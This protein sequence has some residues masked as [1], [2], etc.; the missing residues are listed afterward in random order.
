MTPH[1]HQLE[2]QIAKWLQSL[3][4]PG[5]PR[6]IARMSE[7]G[8]MKPEIVRDEAG[9]KVRTGRMVPRDK[10]EDIRA[11]QLTLAMLAEHARGSKTYSY[12][13]DK[14]GQAR[15]GAIDVDQGGQAA[16]LALLRAGAELGVTLYAIE[17]ASGEKHRG[18]HVR[19]I[20]DS[21]YPAGHIKALMKA[22]AERAGVNTK[23]IWP[24]SNQGIRGALG[25][26][27]TDQTRGQLLLQSGE[28]INL[29]RDLAAGFAAIQALPHNSAPPAIAEPTP[30]PNLPKA[31]RQLA[32]AGRPGRATLADVRA[33]F[34]AEHT[35]EQL[36]LEYGAQR[37][38]GGYSCPCGVQ[39]THQT[40][41]YIS[42]RG[43]LF[44]FSN[45]CKWHTDK[46]WDAFGLYVLVEHG[47]DPIAA[48]KTLN[49]IAPRQA[50]QEAPTLAPVPLPGRTPAQI[51]DA[52]RKR[53]QRAAAA[54]E[55]LA[56]VRARA[57][58][59]E[60]LRP[61]ERAILKAML[62]IAGDRG[63][64]RPSK[65]RIAALAGCGLGTVKRALFGPEAGGRL[66]GRY[67]VS[68]GDGGG[69]NKTAIRT[70]LRGSFASQMIPMLDHE[71]DS[72]HPLRASE[73]APS[74]Q[75]ASATAHMFFLAPA[76]AAVDRGLLGYVRSLAKEAAEPGWAL[77]DYAEL[78]QV[79]LEQEAGRLEQLLRQ[80]PIGV[81]EAPAKLEPAGQLGTAAGA[82]YD[83]AWAEPLTGKPYEGRTKDWLGFAEQWAAATSAIKVR[84]RAV[85]QA[86]QQPLEGAAASVST[87]PP[88]PIVAALL[89]E[90]LLL[91]DLPLPAVGRLQP[92]PPGPSDPRYREFVWRWRAAQQERRTAAQ[93]AYFKHQ[94]LAFCDYAEPSEAERRW[95]AF[96]PRP[97]TDASTGQLQARARGR[98]LDRPGARVPP[99]SQAQ[100]ALQLGF[101]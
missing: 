5:R 7:P 16:L 86:E 1:Q 56:D 2:Q 19:A 62:T 65:E 76:P 28:V 29:D 55:T 101:G 93:R 64:C 61:T 9:R 43:R 30:A 27:Q 50:H 38:P 66:E 78:D 59:D 52:Q 8:E 21:L 97:P 33:R 48:A 95:L 74:P 68:E 87:T 92:C 20:F 42:S 35:I 90:Q 100:Q 49:P 67:F 80:A 3:L 15:E 63:W 53:A 88:A 81:D 85:D 18:G 84:A 4:P 40:T 34:N 36:L 73:R 37:A 32:P 72:Y 23:E 58:A 25:F 45:R 10:Y 99:P 89:A 69:P 57:A 71:S 79:A 54:A 6:R 83:P 77:R 31:A 91:E 75:P 22:I 41:L 11:E 46:G 51:T 26:H 12:T 82:S 14:G 96:E 60:T 44:S 13:L 98:P 17:N 39:H 94:A 47:N 70:F 24:G